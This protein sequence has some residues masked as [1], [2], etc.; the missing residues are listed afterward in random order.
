MILWVVRGWQFQLAS[1]G[2]Q[3][4]QVLSLARGAVILHKVS[5][6]QMEGG[7]ALAVA[8]LFPQRVVQL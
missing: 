5:K 2:V 1:D 6:G 3:V 4:V 7:M 8:E